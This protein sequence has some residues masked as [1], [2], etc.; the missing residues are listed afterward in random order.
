MNTALKI[1]GLMVL[2]GAVVI[3]GGYL[4]YKKDA[5]IDSVTTAVDV[6]SDENIVNQT[7]HAIA[8]DP[9]GRSYGE[10]IYDNKEIHPLAW[11]FE[12]VGKLTGDLP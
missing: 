1:D 3:I 4:Y 10:Y 7:F 5:I 8:N 6:T 2:T 9:Q 11:I 12:G